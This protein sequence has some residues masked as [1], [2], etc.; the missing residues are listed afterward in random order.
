MILGVDHIALSCCDIDAATEL[1]RRYGFTTEFSETGLENSA[2]KRPFLQTY[3]PEHSIAFCRPAAGVALELTMH[4]ST[5][6]G[7]PASPGVVFSGAPKGDVGEGEKDAVDVGRI[8]R[9]ALG[10]PDVTRRRWPGL[11]ASC[12]YGIDDGN[13]PH[14]RALLVPAADLTAATTFWQDALGCRQVG[15]GDGNTA[16]AWRHLRFAAPVPAWSLDILLHKPSREP[17]P[18]FLDSPGF[19]CLA[20]LTNGIEQDR[21]TALRSGVHEASDIFSLDVKGRRLRLVI[22]RT[23]DGTLIELIEIQRGGRHAT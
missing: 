13:T 23:N 18:Y 9:A 16:G 3:E 17:G 8:I 11:S 2:E 4:S 15:E 10:H 6:S 1:L 14:T 5:P 21:D 7:P 12:W 19:P 20:L 22:L